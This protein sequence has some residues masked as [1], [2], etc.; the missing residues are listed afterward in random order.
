MNNESVF[1]LSNI[2]LRTGCVKVFIF[3]FFGVPG[4]DLSGTIRGEVG[5][6]IGGRKASFF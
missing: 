1:I 6:E 2:V 3:F 4:K 5:V